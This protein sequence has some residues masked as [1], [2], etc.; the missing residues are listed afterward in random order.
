MSETMRSADFDFPG[1]SFLCN[2]IRLNSAPNIAV[3]SAR[4]FSRFLRNALG[5]QEACFSWFSSSVI[6]VVRSVA[7]KTDST[8]PVFGSTPT[9]AW[10][11]LAGAVGDTV[12]VSTGVTPCFFRLYGLGRS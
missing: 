1:G 8:M 7:M 9:L 11:T 3:I 5:G 12:W 4:I 6:S 2:S 10:S